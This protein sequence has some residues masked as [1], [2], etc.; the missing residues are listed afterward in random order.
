MIAHLDMIPSFRGYIVQLHFLEMIDFQKKGRR[1][2][3]NK[4][5]LD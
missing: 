5:M 2:Q 1:K 4:K 3:K